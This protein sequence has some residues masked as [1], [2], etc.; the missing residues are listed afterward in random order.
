M[1]R[2]DLEAWLR[3][4][5]IANQKRMA[6]KMIPG[7]RERLNVP[8]ISALIINLGEGILEPWNTEACWS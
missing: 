4:K 1:A 6:A 5:N 8:V 2:E 3:E 7:P